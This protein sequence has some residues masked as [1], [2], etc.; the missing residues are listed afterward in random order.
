MLVAATAWLLAL[1]WIAH[2]LYVFWAA[3][4]PPEYA[5]H[6]NLL[7]QLTLENFRQAM[8]MAPFWRY[9]INTFTL[10]SM[11]LGAQLVLCPESVKLLQC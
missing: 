11:I 7:A 5:V 9:G 4:H 6:F 1:I 2:L 10:V 8:P 3:F